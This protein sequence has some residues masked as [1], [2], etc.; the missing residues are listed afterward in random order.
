MQGVTSM[1]LKTEPVNELVWHPILDFYRF[2]TNFGRL[3]TGY[4]WFYWN[5]S[6]AN[7]Q[8]NRLDRLV[9]LDF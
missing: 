3:L 2:L 7:C 9:G 6:V 4:G 5:K 1:V 8:L